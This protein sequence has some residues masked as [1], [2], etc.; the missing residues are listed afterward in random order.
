MK[1]VL[2]TAIAILALVSCK[3]EAE[4]T[5]LNVS[6]SNGSLW[7]DEIDEVKAFLL[8]EPAL[9]LSTSAFN[10]GNLE[11]RLPMDI[12]G[13]YLYHMG[14]DIT[15]G[16]TISDYSAKAQAVG[17]VLY[18]N[19]AP[20]NYEILG[21]Y[22]LDKINEDFVTFVTIQY[23]NKP[24]DIVG[25]STVYEGSMKQT[26]VYDVHLKRG[27]NYSFIELS[28]ISRNETGVKISTLPN[29]NIVWKI[30]EK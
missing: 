11:F 6:I 18:K 17:F 4:W 20:V 15:S 29:K 21:Y 27:Y 8:S 24:V 26:A 28:R 25:E 19:G 30:D 23:V 22:D 1:K 10:N 5:T 12:D 13:S 14:A 16:V 2:L 7:A 9:E 3:K